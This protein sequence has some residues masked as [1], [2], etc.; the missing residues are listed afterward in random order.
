MQNSTGLRD[1]YVEITPIYGKA[2]ST[3]NGHQL[4][5]IIKIND[6][7]IIKSQPAESTEVERNQKFCLFVPRQSKF[8]VISVN[9][10]NNNT[11]DRGVTTLGWNI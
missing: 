6:L 11:Q 3:T 10:S 4:G 9:T 2:V 1:S 7:E 8:E 5:I